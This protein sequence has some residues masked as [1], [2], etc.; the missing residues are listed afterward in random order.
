[1]P[2][3]YPPDQKTY[4]EQVWEL[5]RQ[6]PHGK[7]ATY[8]QLAQMIPAPKDIDPKDYAAL[9]SRWVGNAL[10]ACPVDVPW[11]RVINSQGQISKRPGAE[12]QR[13]LLEQEGI[14]FIRDRIDL[15]TY[16]WHTSEQMDD[17][18]QGQLF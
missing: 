4:Y 18:T 7:V 12:K 9:G 1:M 5:A 3:T 13:H 8:G 17:P 14:V 15:Q 2:Y 16:H 6:V 10:A 11:Q